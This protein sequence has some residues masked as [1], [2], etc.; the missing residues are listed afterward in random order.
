MIDTPGLI[1][2]GYARSLGMSRQFTADPGRSL[3]DADLGKQ[4][5]K[6]DIVWLKGIV[7][8]IIV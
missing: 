8:A 2:N 1:A 6:L 3:M 4:V 7:Y 5:V